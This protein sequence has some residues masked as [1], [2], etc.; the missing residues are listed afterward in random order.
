LTISRLRVG[1]VTTVAALSL[2]AGAQAA[3]AC[4]EPTLGDLPAR[5]QED[6]LVRFELSGLTPGSEYLVKVNGRERKS[7]VAT[8]DKVSRRFR[9]PQ[10][11]DDQRRVTVSVVIA[12][13]GCENSPWKLEE[14]MTYRPEPEPQ[15]QPEQ[16]Q[17]Q[18]AP[19][20]APSPA[21]DP[22]PSLPAA[23]S[24][25]P[26]PSITDAPKAQPDVPAP[27]VKPPT[28]AP[29]TPTAPGA[30]EPE[31]DAK[32]WLNPLDPYAKGD[33]P[34]PKV[35]EGSLARTD[36]PSEDAN[37]TAALLGL[38]G[39]FLLLAGV[40]AIAWTKFRRYD[41]E[42]LAEILNPEGKLP[43]HLDPKAEDVVAG[44][45]IQERKVL[46]RLRRK[47]APA[48]A[49]A[50]AGGAAAAAG[51]AT[52]SQEKKRFGFLRRR[53]KIDL[54][55]KPFGPKLTEEEKATLSPEEQEKLK[56]ERGRENKAALYKSGRR[57]APLPHFDPTAPPPPAPPAEAANAN[58]A[59]APETANGKPAPEVIPP[60]SPPQAH[61]VPEALTPPPARPPATNGHPPQRS[62]RSEVEGELQRI[63]DDA[64][65]HAEVD[66]ILADAKAE[67]ER[68]GVPIDSELILRALCDETNGAGK[69]SDSTRGE[70]ESR[71]KR[72]VAEERG[73]QRGRG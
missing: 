23:P 26:A 47:P 8:S 14:K 40:G 17:A 51:A 3:Q 60:M 18:P 22:S 70:L 56:E 67:A 62:Y 72:I 20:P 63:L 46:K 4:T 34:P 5:A 45:A 31:K 44:E 38:A 36:L 52:Q 19:A 50:A 42:R 15:T 28:T 66:G 57:K 37:S 25:P 27:T 54:D 9:M 69:L 58:G 43:T 39:V 32:T 61:G 55:A 13:D 73:E 2:M 10:M 24:P 49:A 68:Q 21:P 33:N 71:F 7:G 12:N 64:G 48:V 29:T 53:P 16:P 41:D 59:P 1:L 6:K 35:K 30:T 11:G 65:L